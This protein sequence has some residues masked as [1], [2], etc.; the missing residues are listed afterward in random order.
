MV[1]IV[2]F[3][4]TISTTQAASFGMLSPNAE[5]H[6]V[7]IGPGPL[8]WE[9]FGHN[10][11]WISDPESGF[12]RI[13]HW[14]LFDF[15]SENFWPKFLQGY[16][17]YSI[18]HIDASDFLQFYME[19]DRSIWLQTLNLNADQKNELA[20]LLMENDSKG[21]RIYRYNYY[22]DN[23]STRTRDALDKVL[24]GIIKKETESSGSGKSFRSNTRRLLQMMPGPY[25]GIHL[26]LGH[27]ADDEISIWKDMF[28]P[29]SLRR[30][31]NAIKLP[32]GMPLIL[33]DKLL[34]NSPRTKE[35]ETIKSYMGFFFPVSAS[36]GAL[37][38]VL[39][40]LAAVKK[41]SARFFLAL[42]ATTWTLLSG[43]LGTIILLIWL[44]T[45][46]RYGHWNENLLH[47]N[48]LSLVLAVLFLVML[49]RGRLPKMGG[50]I[51]YA[52]TALSLLGFAIQIIPF[53]DQ[54]NAEIIALTL[55]AHLG[56]LWAMRITERFNAQ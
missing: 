9:R 45:E 19:S 11:I 30:H 32:D 7:T 10:G 25:L 47:F 29:M 6:L 35:P 26:G 42:L 56:L 18:G 51:L 34:Y 3:I 48:P 20:I 50:L 5:V 12:D 52:V 16:M 2:L 44:V 46:H 1:T 15:Q 38:A 27:P 31:L 8:V 37:F 14:G 39:G 40:Y 24:G 22:L 36:L 41:K 17:D 49:I 13:Y 33:S 21:M 54:V 28:T 23:C 43:L 53:F 4:S 55:P